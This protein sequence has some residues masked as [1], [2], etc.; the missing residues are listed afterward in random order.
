MYYLLYS[1]IAVNKSYDLDIHTLICPSGTLPA[2]I[3]ADLVITTLKIIHIE[4]YYTHTTEHK[5]ARIDM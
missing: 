2:W 4:A 3:Y 1:G 5:I